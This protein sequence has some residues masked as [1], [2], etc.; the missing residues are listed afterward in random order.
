MLDGV[1]AGYTTFRDVD[2]VRVFLETKVSTAFEGL[3]LGTQ[4]IRQALDAT[5]ATGMRVDP[6]CP[7]VRGFIAKR[8]EYA[9]LVCDNHS[10]HRLTPRRAA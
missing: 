8:Q 6:Q 7:V 2:R 9:D 1:P 4:L 3:G 5:W 10:P